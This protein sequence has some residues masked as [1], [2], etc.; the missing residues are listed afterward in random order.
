MRATL[1][2]PARLPFAALLP[3]AEQHTPTNAAPCVR[4]KDHP[5]IAHPPR[6][7]QIRVRSPATY[8]HEQ[9]LQSIPSS[10][11]PRTPG[12]AHDDADAIGRVGHLGENVARNDHGD[13]GLREHAS[14]TQFLDADGVESVGRHRARAASAAQARRARC[15]DA[16]S[17]PAE[18]LPA[19]LDPVSVRP[20]VSSASSIRASSTPRSVDAPQGSHARSIGVKRG[21]F[22]QRPDIVQ[23][24]ATPPM[25]VEDDFARCRVQHAGHHFE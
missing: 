19:R 8:V 3:N 4:R 18:K 1:R 16:A 17:C 5:Y 11:R 22:D 7:H 25:P 2:A 14:L 15:R 13:A 9:P 21:G 20:T 6:R 24:V 23:V 10:G 12:S